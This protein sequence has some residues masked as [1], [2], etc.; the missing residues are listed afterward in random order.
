MVSIPKIINLVSKIQGSK[1]AVSLGKKQLN[2]MA[3]ENKAIQTIVKELKD[4]SL[5]IAYKAKSNYNVAAFK[6]RDGKEAILNGAV[7]LQN[8]G[9]K[10]SIIKYRLNL[11]DKGK[12]ASSNGF[13]DLGQIVD[14]DNMAVSTV[15][16]NGKTQTQARIGDA[17]GISAK[18]DQKEILQM[19]DNVAPEIKEFYET[20]REKQKSILTDGWESLGKKL[21]GKDELKFKKVAPEGFAKASDKVMQED[22]ILTYLSKNKKLIND[23][24]ITEIKKRK[25]II[26]EHMNEIREKFKKTPD[27]L[28]KTKLA[29]K[30]ED[31][32]YEFKNCTKEIDSLD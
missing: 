16:K 3:Q 13:A 18:V 12:A 2:M 30:F 28:D 14:L 20:F 24:R 5:D 9:T 27:P 4:P 31:L 25:D 17:L 22:D 21:S 8:P 19:T 6:L 23:A 29:Q 26:N 11:G 15:V 1:G 32:M 7:S 10:E